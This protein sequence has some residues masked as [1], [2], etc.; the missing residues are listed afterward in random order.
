LF[1]QTRF[2][3]MF[4]I[5]LVT[6]AAAFGQSMAT[7]MTSSSFSSGPDGSFKGSATFNSGPLFQSATVADAPYSGDEVNETV[8]TLA[9]GT[10]ITH[11]MAGPHVSRDSAGRTRVERALVQRPTGMPATV[12]FPADVPTIVEITD[13][14]AGCRYVLDP[15]NRIAHRTAIQAR[16]E[17]MARPAPAG[18]GS[19]A[20]GGTRQMQ[21]GAGSGDRAVTRTGV[22][23]DTLAPPP[24][25]VPG[26]PGA[27]GFSA[28]RAAQSGQAL[29]PTTEDLG[30]QMIDGVLVAGT[31]TTATMPVG[32]QG[33]DRPLVNTT[34]T[35]TSPD[36]KITVLRVTT[37]P[38][39]GVQT[40]RIENLSRTAPDPILFMPPADY[41]VVDETGTFTINFG[42]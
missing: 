41:A 21:L 32:M 17:P 5:L 42:Q 33:N 7:G 19:G 34:E 27:V 4:A 10:H 31:R 28:P 38:I 1:M 8:Q 25:G 9:D 39:S 14:V 16:P 2:C 20:A 3:F 29:R 26:A 24:Q 11:T 15:M 12:G 30:S 36:L 23:S 13:P 37:S 6:A 40:F 18:L 22:I 35:W